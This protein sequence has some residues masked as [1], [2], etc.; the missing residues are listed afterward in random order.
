VQTDPEQNS[1]PRLERRRIGALVLLCLILF[2]FRLGGHFLWDIDEGM[3]AVTAKNMVVTGDWVTPTFNGEVFFDKTPLSNWFSALAFIVLGFTE[4][5]ARLPAALLSLAGV[6]LTYL[7]G[8]RIF[9]GRIAFLSAVAL[10]TALEYVILARAVV[11]DPSLAFF[12][13][14]S[15]LAFYRAYTDEAGRVKYLLLMYA[16]AGVAVLAKGPLG[17]LL[18]TCVI[19][20]FLALRWD[21]GFLRK[22]MI[23]RGALI[24]LAVAVPWY[25]MVAL[26][27][28]TFLEYFFL[29]QN[30]GNF[31]SATARHAQPWHY[32]LPVLLVILLPWS[33]FLPLALYRWFRDRRK[34]GPEW[35]FVIIW[36]S[37]MLLF[38]SAASAKLA[39]Y[40]LPMFPAVAFLMGGLWDRLLGPPDR[41]LR[42]GILLTQLGVALIGF[43]AIYYLWGPLRADPEIGP[44]LPGWAIPS[45]TAII[46]SGVALTSFLVL[47]RSY[48]AL[49]GTLA[50]SIVV[51]IVFFVLA[52]APGLNSYKSSKVIAEQMDELLPPGAKMT[53]YRWVKDSGMFYT[54]RESTLLRNE[55]ELLQHLGRAG[56]LC[57]IDEKRLP[58][59]GNVA[60]IRAAS[61]LVRHH[62]NKLILEGLGPYATE[63]SPQPAEGR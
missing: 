44:K 17:V 30:L 22:M 23:V 49:F 31:G 46:L 35:L 10:A 61:R 39:T 32:Y 54:G 60:E 9:G 8:W 41:R 1:D 26:R 36:F 42:W 13:T 43:A 27:N 52:I 57:L 21:P 34:L 62:G 6:L 19:G 33:L 5:A 25:V 12:V 45:V 58:Q 14:L 59:L 63:P 16:S 29:K 56:A 48:R 4:F 51:A 11:H 40:L 20:L 53:T 2:F 3:H 38:F 15:L 50:G 37:F 18:P 55:D 7:F 28:D 24:T 47:R